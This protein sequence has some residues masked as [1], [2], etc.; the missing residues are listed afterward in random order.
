M[1]GVESLI[2][3]G[4]CSMC[5]ATDK[6]LLPFLGKLIDYLDD[7]SR[8]TC[9]WRALY[10]KNILVSQRFSYCRCLVVVIPCRT[11]YRIEVLYPIV[12]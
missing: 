9:T 10:K 12:S 8:L 4:D 1:L 3:I 5:L 2:N 7:N 11:E 6:D